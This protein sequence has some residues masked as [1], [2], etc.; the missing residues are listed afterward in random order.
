MK[1]ASRCF[2]Y[3]NDERVEVLWITNTWRGFTKTSYTLYRYRSTLGT[4]D[5]INEEIKKCM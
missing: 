3:Y 1:S 2:G 4:F 5:T